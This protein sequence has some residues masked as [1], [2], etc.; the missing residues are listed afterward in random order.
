VSISRLLPVLLTA[1]A[2]SSLAPPEP[3]IAP[4]PELRDAR[5]VDEIAK[6]A[7]SYKPWGRIDERPNIAPGLCRMP[8]PEDYGMASQV[9]QS[10]APDGPHGTKLY[11][12]WASQRAYAVLPKVPLDEGFTIVKESFAA[13]TV[14]PTAGIVASLGGVPPPVRWLE[15]DHGTLYTGAP[16]GLYVMKKVGTAEGTDEGWIYGTVAPTGEVTS[17]GRVE[18]CMGCH[19]AAPHGRLFGLQPTLQRRVINR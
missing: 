7:A 8:R 12:L 16:V 17:A 11:Y 6:A 9:R 13:T 14:A 4:A 5:F 1:C 2:S 19:E 15:T 10:Q 18:S 3:A